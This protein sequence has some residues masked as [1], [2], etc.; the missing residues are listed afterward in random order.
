M[1]DYAAAIG[2]LAARIA[3]KVFDIVQEAENDRN[4]EAE[5]TLN[6][7]EWRNGLALGLMSGLVTFCVVSGAYPPGEGARVEEYLRRLL[8]AILE[9]YQNAGDE[10][11]MLQ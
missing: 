8:N 7:E 2:D 6:L 4:A 3:H 9:Q 11:A 1:T 5:Q 10:G